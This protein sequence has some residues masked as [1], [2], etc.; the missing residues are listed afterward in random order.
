MISFDPL[1]DTMKRKG[2][3]QYK[4]LKDYHFSAGQLNRLRRNCN[5]NTY[6]L[7]QLCKI[8]DCKIEDVAV[9]LEENASETE[10]QT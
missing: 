1:W 7:N 4:L 8:L 2:V 9:Y 10:E 5:V 6:T 3:S